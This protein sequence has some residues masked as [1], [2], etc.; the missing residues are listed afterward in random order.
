MRLAD[1]VGG[2][3]AFVGELIEQFRSDAPELLASARSALAAGD[4]AELRR[5]AH[6]LKSNAAT[7]GAGRLADR[8]RALEEA[9][10]SGDL[11]ACAPMIEPV[12][13]ELDA[14]LIALPRA[15]AELAAGSPP[16]SRSSR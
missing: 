5:A 11:E 7:F 6:T 14:V 1:G 16:S 15:S 9:A 10:K 2:D 12:G 13:I 3:T 8:S 4:A